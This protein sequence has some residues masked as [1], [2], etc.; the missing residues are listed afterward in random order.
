MKLIRT[1]LLLAI[2]FYFFSCTP[3]KPLPNYLEK[4]TDTTGEREV[5]IPELRI[6]K[7]DILSIQVY[8]AAIDPKADEIFNLRSGGTTSA[9]AAP[10]GFLVDVNGNIEYPRLGSFHA[11][12]LTKDE[13]AA[14]IK[15]RLVDPIQLLIDPIVI[16]RFQN[17]K[18]TVLGEVG[19]QGVLN[20]PGE[21]VTILEAVGLAGGITDFGLKNT[22][23]VVRQI[24]G[25][26]NIGM[27]DLSSD[28][29]FMSPYYNLMQDDVVLVEPAKRKAKRVEEDRALQRVS[30][31][32][33][34]I[35]AIALL[36]GIF[37]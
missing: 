11:E 36:Y 19:S 15:K 17:F 10:V 27:I 2:P 6:Q 8:S 13:L 33:S 18:V 34:L 32:L 3:Q 5:T 1:V 29:L 20:I 9:T 35:T 28:S 21:K 7:F 25:K 14:Q 12:G 37:Q 26:R 30:F 23:K 16:I 4:I 31:G 24:D 22:V